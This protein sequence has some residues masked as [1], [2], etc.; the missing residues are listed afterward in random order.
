VLR[1]RGDRDPSTTRVPVGGW[2]DRRPA[3]GLRARG[4]V[5]MSPREDEVTLSA[6]RRDAGPG[7]TAPTVVLDRLEAKFTHAVVSF[8][9]ADG[10]PLSVATGFRVDADR[11]LVALEAVA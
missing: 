9:D 11:G 3:A 1:T 5:A 8:L 4:G 2:P 6:W 10:Y 7:E